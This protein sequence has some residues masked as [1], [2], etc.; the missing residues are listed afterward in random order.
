M[1]PGTVPLCGAAA[2][3][4]FVP[5][6]GGKKLAG[7]EAR[8]ELNPRGEW[9]KF[10]RPGRGDRKNGDVRNYRLL[11]APPPGR[12]RSCAVPGGS[13]ALHPRLI[14]V[15]PPGLCRRGVLPALLLSGVMAG[16]AERQR[17]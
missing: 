11:P 3:D 12:S 1:A 6:A 2:V 15:G 5:P 10:Y 14:S 4:C 7:C 9:V 16:A 17:E 13:A 8:N